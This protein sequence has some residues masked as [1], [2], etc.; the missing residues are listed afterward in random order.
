MIAYVDV[1]LG[2]Y[3]TIAAMTT[4]ICFIVETPLLISIKS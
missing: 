4:R 2:T 3:H 1:N